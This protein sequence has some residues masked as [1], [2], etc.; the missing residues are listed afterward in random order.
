VDEIDSN[1]QNDYFNNLAEFFQQST[2]FDPASLETMRFHEDILQGNESRIAKN[3]I[4]AMN[5]TGPI[6]EKY[7]NTHKS[8]AYEHARQITGLKLTLG[9][10]SRF[11]PTHFNS[12]K[13]LLL[14]SDTILIP[15]PVLP[16]LED[17]RRE[18]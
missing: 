6:L 14:Y 8:T 16:W 4:A 17:E 3:T 15:D 7:Y 2:G 11:M 5:K 12:V 1:Y 9:G 18:E 13:K 10:G